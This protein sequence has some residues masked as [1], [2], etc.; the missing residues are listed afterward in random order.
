MSEHQ[1]LDGKERILSSAEQAERSVQAA[2][3]WA[4]QEV[5][6]HKISTA[7][8]MFTK[9]ALEQFLIK[10]HA[11]G[12]TFVYREIQRAVNTSLAQKMKPI[13]EE[14]RLP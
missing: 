9:S 6:S 13:P 5:A 7:A 8:I 1:M 4:A 12:Q 14:D 10:A 2:R 3:D 11:A